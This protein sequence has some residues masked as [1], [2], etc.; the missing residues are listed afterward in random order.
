MKKN[1]EKVTN[2]KVYICLCHF[3]GEES[4]T[5]VQVFN[6]A[7]AAIECDSKAVKNHCNYH[8]IMA[9]DIHDKVEHDDGCPMEMWSDCDEEER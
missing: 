1:G 8:H 7:E 5:H 9:Q 3:P 4:A 2:Q 6:N